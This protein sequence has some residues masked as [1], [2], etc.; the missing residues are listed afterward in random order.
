MTQAMH[1]FRTSATIPL[2][3]DTDFSPF[4]A[5]EFKDALS[6]LKNSGFDG[7]ELAIAH[8]VEVNGAELRKTLDEYD[9]Q[10]PTI[11]TGQ[12]LGL[13]GISLSD[14]ND[15]GRARAVKRIRDYID[16][17][18]EINA[19][20]VTIGMIRGGKYNKDQS[21]RL[22]RLRDSLN[23][24][25]PYAKSKG[26]RLILEPINRYEV[27]FLHSCEDTVRFLKSL[28]AGDIG[29]LYDTFHSNIEDAC[30]K[31]TIEEYGDLIF[32]VHFADSNRHLPGD[33]HIDFREVCTALE[34]KGFSGFVSLETL[35][36]PDREYIKQHAACR[37]KDDQSFQP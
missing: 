1:N 22:A 6:W 36:L 26:I 2:Q 20:H 34:K 21:E 4:F 16:L 24:C 7:A 3:F 11:S 14:L 27:E 17:A 18:S 32:H 15:E 9:L 13:D 8:P 5:A 30:M 23:E 37:I 25:L 10:V 19:I 35:N 28:P 33:G 31:S 12:S 29:L